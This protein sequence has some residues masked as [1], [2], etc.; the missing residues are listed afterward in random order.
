MAGSS[1][2]HDGDALLETLEEDESRKEMSRPLRD[3]AFCV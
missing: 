3:R 2:S 1:I